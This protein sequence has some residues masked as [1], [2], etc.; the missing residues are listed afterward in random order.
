MFH[1]CSLSELVVTW[2]RAISSIDPIGLLKPFWYD[3]AKNVYRALFEKEFRHYLWLI[4]KYGRTRRYTRLTVT[5]HGWKM[6]IPDI[7]SFFSAYREIFVEEIYSFPSENRKPVVLDCGANIGL[8]ILYLKTKYPLAEVIAY[9]A[10]PTIFQYLKHN[11]EANGITGVELH[12]IAIWSSDRSIEFS[13]EGADGGR[14]SVEKDNNI[15]SVPAVSLAAILEGRKFDF[16]KLDIEGAEVPALNGCE[17][18]LS[19]TDY[20]FVEFHSF[21]HRKQDLGWIIDMFERSGFRVH[22]HPPFIAKRPFEGIHDQ[23]G[24]DMQ[25][26]L[27]F[28]KGDHETA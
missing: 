16:I 8:S 9:E 7:A 17:R 26:N 23:N 2:F 3:A 11:M 27:F 25:L 19:K 4:L 21:A 1:Q 10:D 5:V 28:W 14:V 24:M 13:V 20:V 12:N 22:I 6:T 15:I 18:Y